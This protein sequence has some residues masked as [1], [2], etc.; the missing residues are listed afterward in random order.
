MNVLIVGLGVVSG[1]CSAVQAPVN[2]TLAAHIGRLRA[3]C[4]SFLG[5]WIVV[6]LLFLLV[7]PGFDKGLVD[8][9]WWQYLDG[10][11]GVVMVVIATAAVPQ[12]GV[13]LATMTMMLGQ[14]LTRLVIDAFGLFNI[15]A[16]PLRAA[17]LTGCVLALR[18]G[19]V[20]TDRTRHAE[21]ENRSSA[22]TFAAC[23][24]ELI[25]GT[26]NAVQ[27]PTNAALASEIGRY[28]ANLISFSI[29]LVTVGLLTLCTGCTQT[30][31]FS[32]APVRYGES[33]SVRVWM[34]SGGL[35]GAGSL[36]VN[37][38]VTKKL[39]VTLLMVLF[40]LGQMLASTL[41]DHNGWFRAEKVRISWRRWIGMVLVLLGIPCVGLGC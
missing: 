37:T 6:A 13:S 26:L 32:P 22:R 3:S 2:T 18:G 5:G 34:L 39:G 11:Y 14:I 23:W 40:M 8:I 41:I 36:I 31:P 9:K 1:A 16:R 19:L 21:P 35:W 27:A 24:L 7:E 33:S 10:L 30:R 25:A 4:V 38:T 28:G 29:G 17:R 12:L 20:Y 15:S